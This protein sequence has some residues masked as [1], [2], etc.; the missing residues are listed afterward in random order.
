LR[1]QMNLSCRAEYLLSALSVFRNDFFGGLYILACANG[2]GAQVIQSVNKLGCALAVFNT[3][4]ISVIVWIACLVGVLF[5]LGDRE[6][7]ICSCDIA[8]GAGILLLTILPIG[9]LSWLA[10]AT[11]SL[12][13]L[14]FTNASLP[15]RN[16][17]IILLA[18]TVPMFWSRLLFKFFANPILEIDAS[19]VAWLLGTGRAGNVV[20][21]T[22][23]SGALVILSGCSS[24]TNMSL[25][26][27][28]WITISQSVYHRWSPQ[29]ALWCFLVCVSAVAVNVT[30][31][32]LMGLSEWHYDLIHSQWGDTVG[33]LIIVV[34]AV[35]ISLL[36]LRRDLLCRT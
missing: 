7:I 1:A 10:I 6:E 9:A 29:D 5:I 3:F 16:G 32:S 19:L 11:L 30:R 22:D 14:L 12:Y 31:I 15:R 4:E 8:V 33:N 34:L 18:T 17:A 23:G 27:L 13:I 28:C 20:G 26:F 2:L 21:F 24:L 35:G 36:G 25:A